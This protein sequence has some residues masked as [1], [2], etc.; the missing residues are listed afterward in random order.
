MTTHAKKLFLLIAAS[1]ILGG[2]YSAPNFFFDSKNLNCIVALFLRLE[3]EYW[4]SPFYNSKN[5]N[6]IGALTFFY[7]LFTHFHDFLSQFGVVILVTPKQEMERKSE[8][9]CGV[10]VFRSNF[11][12]E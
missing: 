6:C 10:N 12:V 5:L 1:S 7:D 4:R 3:E 8:W 9:F 11:K 2:Y